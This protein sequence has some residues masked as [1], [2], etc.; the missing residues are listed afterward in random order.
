MPTS[1]T[2]LRE[3]DLKRAYLVHPDPSPR[4]LMKR[5]SLVV[6]LELI[7]GARCAAPM[8]VAP[9]TTV[10]LDESNI[11]KVLGAMRCTSDFSVCSRVDSDAGDFSLEVIDGAGDLVGGS[12]SPFTVSSCP[13]DYFFKQST[14]KCTSCPSGADCIGPSNM[15]A[16]HATP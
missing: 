4:A 16:R 15:L 1:T 6:L 14:G 11:H 3:A 5:P 7:V 13:V 10:V 8:P 2:R 9:E 12:A